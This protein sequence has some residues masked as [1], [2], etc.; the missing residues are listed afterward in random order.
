MW[1][2]ESVTSHNLYPLSLSQTVTLSQTPSPLERDIL[3]GR[4]QKYVQKQVWSIEQILISSTLSRSGDHNYY[5]T[6]NTET[7]TI[8][9]Q[10]ESHTQFSMTFQRRHYL[11]ISHDSLQQYMT[12]IIDRYMTDLIDQCF[13][14]VTASISISILC[15][16]IPLSVRC[17]WPT[18]Q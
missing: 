1:K 18:C 5:D 4:P 11:L 8:D 15:I 17:I 9:I 16:I 14:P 7:Y 2:I 12:V 3:Y 13:H 10:S 6:E